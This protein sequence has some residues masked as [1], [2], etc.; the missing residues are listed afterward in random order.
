L[1]SESFSS[2]SFQLT[3][4]MQYFTFIVSST[5][6]IIIIPSFHILVATKDDVISPAFVG[7]TYMDDQKIGSKQHFGKV[8]MIAT[9]LNIGVLLCIR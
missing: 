9:L 6:Q 5:S 3:I 1:E 8:D 4:G 2:Q 7:L